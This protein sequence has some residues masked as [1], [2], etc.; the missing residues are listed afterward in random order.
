MADTLNELTTA[1][2]WKD[3]AVEPDAMLVD[4]NHEAFE[5]ISSMG[6]ANRLSAAYRR[7]G[8]GDDLRRQ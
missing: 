4:S 3:G 6:T 5:Q 8:V 2:F 1:I 7:P